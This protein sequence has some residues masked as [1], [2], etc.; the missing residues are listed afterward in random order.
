MMNL[1]IISLPWKERVRTRDKVK[2]V[3][4]MERPVLFDHCYYSMFKRNS[5][6]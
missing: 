6:M 4:D 5:T 2:K 3:H 1:N